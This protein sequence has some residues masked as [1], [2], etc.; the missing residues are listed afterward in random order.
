M[1]NVAH[2]NGLKDNIVID[3]WRQ[4]T[5]LGAAAA[6]PLSTLHAYIFFILLPKIH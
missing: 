4:R 2:S 5:D 1:Q 3:F 6:Q